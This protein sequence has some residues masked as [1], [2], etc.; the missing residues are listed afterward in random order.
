[1]K[2]REEVFY[3]NLNVEECDKERLEKSLKAKGLE[4]HIIIKNKLLT[5]ID[6]ATI[7]YTKIAS[8][9]RYDKRIRYVL[10]KYISYLEE[11]YRAVIL[12]NYYNK[13]N[14]NTNFACIELKEKLLGYKNNLND[15]LEH[16]DFSSLIYQIQNLPSSIKQL[17]NLPTCKH[18]KDNFKALKSLRN[19]V[20]HNKFLL[21]YR[22]FEVCYV[23]G[24]DN[25]QSAG[26]RA[27][28]LNL[29]SFLPFN[30][31]NQCRKDIIACA[32]NRNNDNDTKWDL[33]N[34]II[35]NL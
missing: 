18:I 9:Y 15:A 16:I 3:A 23:E 13:V 28:I 7:D 11:F 12:D 29:I 10:F 1:M 19:A 24:V 14:K 21:L 2:K 35:I 34:F 30:V 17:C 20:M 25:N 33:P 32:E 31:G 8:T 4:K 5:W 26:L 6:G 22:G 27:N